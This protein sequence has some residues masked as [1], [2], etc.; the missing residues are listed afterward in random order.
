MSPPSLNW[1]F[2]DLNSYFTSVEQELRPELRGRPVAVVPVM[3]ETTCCIAVS[4]EARRYGLRTGVAVREARARCPEIVLVESRP[5]VYVEMHHSVRAAIERCLPIETVLS[6][7]EFA[8]RLVGRQRE[9]DRAIALA[10]EVKEQIRRRAGGTL[11]CSIGLGPN[12][13]LA[14]IAG[15]M[16]K[17]NGLQAIEQDG[18]PEAL[19]GLA[20]G[21]VPGIGRRMERRLERA[22]VTTMR[23]LSRLSRERLREL[24]GSVLGERMWLE[25][26]GEDL[27]EPAARPACSIS[28]QHILP[29]ALRTRDGCR[30]TAL[31]ML[32]DCAAKLRR[33]EM[34][35]SGLG[36]AIYH[37]DHSFV[38]EA[39]SRIP[40]CQDIFSLQAHLLP[41]WKGAPNHTPASLCV[42][43]TDL[44][45]TPTPSLFPAEH[46]S[47]RMAANRAVET[48]QQRFGQGAVYLASLHGAQEA[49]PTRISFGPPPPL[50]AFDRAPRERK[51][52]LV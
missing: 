20:L 1:L 23:E 38:F 19:D 33:N 31:K 28:R 45:A 21:D 17:P 25:L 41:L 36:V 40:A 24:W 2:L 32:L 10:E 8:C 35:A 50:A 14:K 16:Q 37:L 26:R 30:Q 3:A 6:C 22:G 44:Q 43:L 5:R 15:E 52:A 51:H 13:L 46:A 12:R 49:A 29:P 7:D 42:F 18:L 39:H 34:W 48:L 27:P 9:R 4:Y 11:R 47:A